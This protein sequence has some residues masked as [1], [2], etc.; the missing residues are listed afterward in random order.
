MER[1]DEDFIF[2]GW[3]MNAIMHTSISAEK[4]NTA[5]QTV[6]HTVTALLTPKLP[7]INKI[8]LVFRFFRSPLRVKR[9]TK[10]QASKG[11]LRIQDF[12]ELC[13]DDFKVKGRD[14][15]EIF[16]GMGCQVEQGTHL[17]H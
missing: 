15:M 4:H 2:H 6:K 12:M 13:Q 1:E 3:L 9:I 7:K 5:E 17:L 14:L 8:Y 16:R 10:S 11:T